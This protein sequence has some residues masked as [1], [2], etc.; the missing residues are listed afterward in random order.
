MA[1]LGPKSIERYVHIE[2]VSSWRSF[3]RSYLLYIVTV[4]AI[5][6][7]FYFLFLLST[8][9]PRINRELTEN[10]DLPAK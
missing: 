1:A 5:D 2:K 8:S 4:W 7:I 10:L 3:I 9:E 6:H